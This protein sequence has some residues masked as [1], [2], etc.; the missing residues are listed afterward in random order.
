M[1]CKRY[2]A[3]FLGHLPDRRQTDLLYELKQACKSRCSG[4]ASVRTRL[5]STQRQPVPPGLFTC[6]ALR[7]PD[8]E[9]CCCETFIYRID[10]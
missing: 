2:A 3:P 4:I 6:Q 8:H 5:N 1:G 7:R 10:R 9:P